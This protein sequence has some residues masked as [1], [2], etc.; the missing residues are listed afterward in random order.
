MNGQQLVA[1]QR[2]VKSFKEWLTT[3]TIGIVCLTS[4]AAVT[5][6]NCYSGLK[7]MMI[8]KVLS[9][10]SD[11]VYSNFR[12][13]IEY[14]TNVNHNKAVREILKESGSGSVVSNT[15][16]NGNHSSSTYLTYPANPH[17]LYTLLLIVIQVAF[18]IFFAYMIYLLLLKLGMR[19]LKT[20]LSPKLLGEVER[21]IETSSQAPPQGGDDGED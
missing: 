5:V 7:T 14:N 20:N 4:L 8:N 11:L 10:Q 12:N 3:E 15:S 9:G 21:V 19:P 6:Q 16:N 13:N 18:A 17:I 2:E 1:E